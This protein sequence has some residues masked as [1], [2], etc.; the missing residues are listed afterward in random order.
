MKMATGLE[1]CDDESDIAGERSD[2]ERDPNLIEERFRVDRR[3]LEQML[4]GLSCVRS[5]AKCIGIR[6]SSCPWRFAFVIYNLISP[7]QYLFCSWPRW[8]RGIR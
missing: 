7:L 1:L 4:Q 3:K 8:N 6:L 5:S 2:E